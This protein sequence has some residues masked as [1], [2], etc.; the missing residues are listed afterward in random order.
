VPGTASLS[1][2][3]VGNVTTVC[4]LPVPLAAVRTTAMVLTHQSFRRLL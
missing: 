2:N 4:V 1:F 3:V